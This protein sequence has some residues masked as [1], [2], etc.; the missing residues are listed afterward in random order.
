MSYYRYITG[1]FQH[2]LLVELSYKSLLI[3]IRP[4][5]KVFRFLL[6]IDLSIENMH[7]KLQDLF[8]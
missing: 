8:P 5:N 3:N 1:K 6:N 2:I 7:F 4:M